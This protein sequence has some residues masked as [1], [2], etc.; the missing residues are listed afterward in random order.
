MRSQFN[1]ATWLRIEKAAR[2]ARNIEPKVAKHWRKS[3]KLRV[4]IIVKIGDFF[5]GNFK[6][7]RQMYEFF[8]GVRSTPSDPRLD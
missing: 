1:A 6:N 5:S 4:Q 8:H 3:L 7:Q 2:G